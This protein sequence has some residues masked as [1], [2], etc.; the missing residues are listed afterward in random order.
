MY[1][2]VADIINVFVGMNIVTNEAH[3]KYS[4][5]CRLFMAILVW[6]SFDY[7]LSLGHD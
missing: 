4:L 3:M 7:R 2:I 6:L 1:I 5:E